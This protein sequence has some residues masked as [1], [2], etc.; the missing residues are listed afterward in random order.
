MCAEYAKPPFG[1][2]LSEQILYNVTI[3]RVHMCYNTMYNSTVRTK[4]IYV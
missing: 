2:Y 1:K 3:P 4:T